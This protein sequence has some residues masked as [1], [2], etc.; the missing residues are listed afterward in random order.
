MPNLSDAASVHADT[1]DKIL[2]GAGTYNYNVALAE[3]G[4]VASVGK[5]LGCT[6]GGGKFSVKPNV[7]QL[8]LDQSTVARKGMF[9][10]Q[11]EEA[12][13][14]TN[15][16]EINGD[17]LARVLIADKVAGKD[18]TVMAS[19]ESIEEGDYFPGFAYIG[20]TVSGRPVIVWFENAICTSGIELESKKSEQATPTVLF[21]C[22][23]DLDSGTNTLPYRVVW[24]NVGVSIET[25]ASDPAEV[26]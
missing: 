4:T 10:K 19:K 5:F 22:V 26:V 14:E 18:C 15:W 1:P 11:G 13:I 23:A 6:N 21:Q 8:E 24:P 25:P 2:F 16:T 12:T 7:V 17:D 20:K 9:V 3:D